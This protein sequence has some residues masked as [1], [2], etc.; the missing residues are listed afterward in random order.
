MAYGCQG[1]ASAAPEK[2]PGT[3]LR[4]SRLHLGPL[5]AGGGSSGPPHLC[6]GFV[7]VPVG[8][9]YHSKRVSPVPL[10]LC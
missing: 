1:W 3:S 9:W 10:P 5:F 7:Q 4:T 2:S 6:R 8:S